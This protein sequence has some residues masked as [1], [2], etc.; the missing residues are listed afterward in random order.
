MGR[1]D[2][3][4]W[5]HTGSGP[6]E[7]EARHA[8]A[9]AYACSLKRKHGIR[10]VYLQ[11]LKCGA[12]CSILHQAAV[13]QFGMFSSERCAI[14][15]EAAIF[16]VSEIQ[17]C[18]VCCPRR[19]ADLQISDSSSVRC[20]IIRS[21]FSDIR[22]LFEYSPMRNRNILMGRRLQMGEVNPRF[23]YTVLCVSGRYLSW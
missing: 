7:L 23:R 14:K 11:L 6:T 4:L 16:W 13:V 22:V 12:L 20:T 21:G 17:L 18:A 2:L 10:T 15:M 8:N 9:L 19:A 1:S 5:D 3:C